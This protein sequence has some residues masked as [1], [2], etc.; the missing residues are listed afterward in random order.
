M[1]YSFECPIDG[2][3]TKTAFGMRSHIS[4][5]PIHLSAEHVEWI[6][7][8]LGTMPSDMG[9]LNA[10]LLDLVKKECKIKNKP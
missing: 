10:K 4:R 7:K 1:D 6:V 8:R 3:R 2:Y 9:E 5:P